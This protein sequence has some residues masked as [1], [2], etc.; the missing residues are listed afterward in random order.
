MKKPLEI[1]FKY[2]ADNISLTE[3]KAFCES[4]PPVSF[5]Q[6]SGYD[7]FYSDALNS[8]AFCR[9]RVGADIN[10]VTFKRKTKE[11]NNFV[12]VEHNI[13]LAPVVTEPQVRALVSEFGYEYDSTIYKSCFVYKY[14]W[15][16]LVY[17]ICYNED[18]KELGRFIEIEMKEDHDWETEESAWNELVIVEKLC[19]TLG[20]SPQARIKKSLYELYGKAK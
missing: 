15:Y 20:I 17:Y 7:Y 2:K 5:I 9:F 10:Q 11:K 14:E 13:D 16:T 4:K 3:F 8:G 6:A 1:E 18:L 12:R 19:K